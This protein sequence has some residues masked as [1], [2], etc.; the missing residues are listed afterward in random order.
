MKKIMAYLIVIFI[1]STWG[2]WNLPQGN[3]IY[4]MA[5]GTGAR[6]ALA[7]H[8]EHDRMLPAQ[9]AASKEP[10]AEVPTVEIPLEKQQMIGVKTATVSMKPVWKTIRT[11]GR[12]ETD[13]KRLG[14][15]NIHFDA[16]IEKLYVDYTGKNVKSG[17]PLVDVYSYELFA[18]QQEF[19]NALKWKEQ[20]SEVID[21]KVR[22]MLERDAE[23]I[24]AA[25]KQ[26]LSMWNV[27][28][29]QIKLIA[30]TGS[31][32]RTLTIYSPVNGYVIQKTAIQGMRV[33]TGDKLFDIADL[34]RVWIIADIYEYELPMIHVG[35]DAKITM[36]YFPGKVFTAAIDYIYP[37]LSGETRTIKIRFS[38]PN[39][40][41]QLKPQ[42]FTNVEIKVNMGKRLVV[43]EDAV[44]D[45]GMRQIVYVDKG[46]GYFEP[47]DVIAG[48]I[49][50][51]MIEISK[52]LKAKERIATAATFLIDAEA[53]L[54]GIVK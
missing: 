40:E 27:T 2:V 47:R 49:A 16:W 54:K 22:S 32:T 8:E 45:T 5:I 10:V 26:P 34:S 53:R 44:I 46:D 7:Q 33:L 30:E 50:D 4:S 35:D 1:G 43:P 52:G 20:R 42:M 36:S 37:V 28:D 29:D 9:P 38:I 21:E 14:T 19:I 13:E 6:D 3:F 24:A 41:G 31:P 17:E 15:I 51:G 12:I 48:V 39:P 18:T 11:V 25:A 23:A